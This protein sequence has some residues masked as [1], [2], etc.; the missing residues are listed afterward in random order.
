MKKSLLFAIVIC[1]ISTVGYAAQPSMMPWTWGSTIQWNSSQDEVIPI[2]KPSTLLP[3]CCLVS[4]VPNIPQPIVVPQGG[5]FPFTGRLCEIC[6]SPLVTDVWWGV[7]FA[8]IFYQQGAFLNVSLAGGQCLSATMTQFVPNNAPLGTYTY[9]AYCGTYNTQKDDSSFFNFTV[10]GAA[11]GNNNG[12]GTD[13]QRQAEMPAQFKI[14]G[15]YP[16]P[17]NATT[18]INYM[19]PTAANVNLSIYNLMG[20]KVTTLIDGHNEA[21]QHSVSWDAAN[22]SSGIYFYRLS[23]GERVFTE[24][25][26]LLK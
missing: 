25:M 3:A 17:F 20:Q 15:N 7:I 19:M 4:I 2:D 8:N 12:W 16:N 6:G 10:V 11:D 1:A 23:A 26:T 13:A 18:T 24:R 5:S 9:V 22:Y 14:S 21:G